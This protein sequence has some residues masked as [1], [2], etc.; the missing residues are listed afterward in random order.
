LAKGQFYFLEDAQSQ[1][2]VHFLRHK[3]ETK[4]DKTFFNALSIKNPSDRAVTFRTNFSYPVSWSFIGEKNQKITLAPGD[5]ILIPFRAAPSINAKGEIGYSIVASL[6]DLNG[7]TFKNE[8]SFVNIPKIKNV[9]IIPVDRIVYFDQLKKN[10][11]IQLLFINNGNTDETFYINYSFD[12]LT[13]TQGAVEGAYS[14]ELTLTPYSDTIV[15]LPVFVNTNKHDYAKKFHRIG[16][17]VNSKDTT[18]KTSIW[19]KE[20]E[21]KF[22]NQIPDNYKFLSVELVF[23]N[24]FSQYPMAL[25]GNVTGNILFK[26]AGTIHYRLQTMGG[27]FYTDPWRYGRYYGTYEYKNLKLQVGDVFGD[28]GQDMFGRGVDMEY[29]ISKKDKVR[30]LA[31][32]SIYKDRLN[33][34]GSY[35]MNFRKFGVELAG[36]FVQDKT[37]G[38]DIAG[39]FINTAFG[40]KKIGDIKLGVTATYAD[41]Y[42][43]NYDNT[44]G[45]GGIFRYYNQWNKKTTLTINSRYGERKYLGRFNGRLEAHAQLMHHLSPGKYILAQYNANNYKPALFYGDSL[46][47]ETYNFYDEVKATYNFYTSAKVLLTA[48]TI[49]ESRSANNFLFSSGNNFEL[50]TRN[51]L[52]YAAL[53]IRNRYTNNIFVLSGKFGQ[54]FITDFTQGVY[55]EDYVNK[56]WFSMV[57][58]TSYRSRHLGAYLSYYHG[59]YGINQQYAYFA[60]NYYSKS[61]RIMPYLDYFIYKNYIRLVS[62]IAYNYDIVVKTSRLNVGTD[63]KGYFGKTWELTFTNTINY[64]STVDRITDDRYTYSGAYFEFRIKKDININQPRYQYHNLKVI[65]FKDLNGNNVKDDKEPGIKDVLLTVKKDDSRETDEEYNTAGFFMPVDLLSD[66]NG[67]IKYD[68]IPNGFYTIEYMPIAS[69][70]GAY[71]SEKSRQDLYI[72]KNQTIY[73]PFFENNKIFGK[74]ILNRSKLSNLGQISP[75][76]IRVTAEDTH[77]KKYSALTDDNGNFIIYVPSVDKYKVHINNIFFENFE[78]EQ[79]DYEVQLNGYRQFEVN[80][81]FNEKRR[82]INFSNSYNYAQDA[83]SNQGVELIRR[84]NLSGTVKDATTLKPLVA[85]VKVVDNKGRVIT[86]AKS[87]LKTGLFTLS[88]VAGDNY[89]VEVI[90]DGYWYY[91]EKL[92]SEQVVTFKN[93]RKSILLKGITVGQLIPMKT[94]NFEQGSTEIPATAFPELERLLK[95]LRKNPSVK[96]TVHGHADDQEILETNVDLATERAKIVAKYLI[97]NGYSRVRYIGHSNTKPIADNDTEEGRQKNRRVEIEVTGK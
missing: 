34:G 42:N 63:I 22:Y 62:H 95:V 14:Q 27:A 89:H 88:F 47:P 12:Q 97:A 18:Y 77:G 28:L 7:N 4:P 36:S 84:T 51:A 46:S 21:N 26:K 44:L 32:K 33:I 59:P 43:A 38:A 9:K 73:I 16:I 86:T 91:S 64:S 30:L 70:K 58:S 41:W 83:G 60:N 75:G 82:K 53:R 93:I 94:L 2:K 68:N 45:F 11:D 76:N 20:L 65:F 74:V 79:N 66:I 8:Y 78:L 81:I 96:I 37:I 3:I 52:G 1:V 5:S 54:T 92:Y 15:N 71:T 69:I 23:Q 56:N 31:S 61:I 55:N 48:G 57:L 72:G 6:S 80:F 90:G 10:T 39:G 87:N 19:A 24:L 29:L 49:S 85:T 67:I 40:S 17:E 50:K 13:S 25:S 35:Q